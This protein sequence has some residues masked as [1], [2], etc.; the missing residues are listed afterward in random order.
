VH[1]VGS[2]Y[3]AAF[4]TLI[5]KSPDWPETDVTSDSVWM[6]MAALASGDRHAVRRMLQFLGDHQD[7]DGKILHELTTSGHC[8]YDA[9]D[10]TL[11]I[12]GG[13]GAYKRAQGQM[14]LHCYVGADDVGRCDFAFKVI[15]P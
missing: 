7:L 15:L 6:S 2:T 12:I 4:R 14:K 5:V 9:A 11:A 8:H 13:T 1:L 10:S 3:R